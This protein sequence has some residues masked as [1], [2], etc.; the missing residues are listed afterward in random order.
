[1]RATGLDPAGIEAMRRFG[2]VTEADGWISVEGAGADEVP[3][4]VADMVR[5]GARVYAV[6][7]QHESLEDRFMSLLGGEQQETTWT[8]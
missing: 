5:R 3:E 7:P 4:M 8:P 2:R 6:E 1:V